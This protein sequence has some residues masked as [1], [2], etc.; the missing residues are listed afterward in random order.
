MAAG[1]FVHGS[2]WLPP[3]PLFSVIGDASQA[4]RMGAFFAISG[5]LTAL[6]LGRRDPGR[7][8]RRRLVQ[9]GVPSLVGLTVLSPLIWLTVAT[10]H[11]AAYGWPLLPFEWHHMWF[12]FGLILYSC[13]A[14]ALHAAD[15]RYALVARLDGLTDARSGRVAVLIIATASAAL[16]GA[17]LP[18]LRWL[19]PPA[20]LH[21]FGNAQLIAGYLPMFLLGFVL[22]RADRLRSQ[23]VQARGFGLAICFGAAAAYAAAHLLT[24]LAGLTEY[25]RFVVAA[26]CPPAAFLL[27]L[28]SALTIR[29]VPALVG[30]FS[31]ASYTI[32]ILHYPLS[33]LI[34]THF[35]IGVEPHLAY[36]LSILASGTASFAVHVL[37][38]Q[39]SPALALLLNGKF[40]RRTPQ[41]AIPAPDLPVSEDARIAVAPGPLAAID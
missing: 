14:V 6:A 21:S 41:P 25:V 24:P 1:L 15:R 4:F 36:F 5:L 30:H 23:M 2:L 9:L 10:S 31:E 20:Y 40:E 37:A 34:N 11:S 13:V 38:V 32:Y 27:I 8:L 29:R 28:R 18:V 33:V 3:A 26:L 35:A 19:L 39:S 12:L 16:L 22:A 17:A 7:W